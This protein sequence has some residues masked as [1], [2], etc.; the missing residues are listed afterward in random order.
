MTFRTNLFQEH[1]MQKLTSLSN[2]PRTATDSRELPASK[3][4]LLMTGLALG[5]AWFALAGHENPVSWILGLP[6]ILAA[7][8]AYHRLSS[9]TKTGLTAS[10]ILRLVPTFVWES[11]RGGVDVASRVLRVRPN[12]NPGLFEY[13]LSLSSPSARVLFVDLISL[14][15][16]TLSADV[17]GNR[18]RIHALDTSQVSTDEIERLERLVAAVFGQSFPDKETGAK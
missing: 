1:R 12:L 15:P 5:A 16:G 13:R 9:P 3:S 4:G 8:W 7:T 14:L 6:T 2:A 17:R 11:F 18:V 10:G